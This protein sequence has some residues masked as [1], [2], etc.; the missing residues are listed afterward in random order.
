MPRRSKKKNLFKCAVVGYGSS[1]DT[2]KF[3]CECIR[4]TKGLDLVAVCDLNPERTKVAKKDFPWISTYNDLG[5]M[6]EKQDV[7]L[8]TIVT[9]HNT[10]APLAIQCLKAGKHVIVEKPMCITTAEATDMIN[11]AKK[12]NL[13]LSVFHN[14]RYDG[15]FRA[16]KETVDKKTIGDVFHLEAF[17]GG[18][19]SPGSW[20]RSSKEISGGAFYDWGSHLMDWVLNIIPERIVGLAGFFHKLVWKEVTN[21]DQVE[22]VI[23][24]LSGAVADVQLSNIAS[25]RKPR[26]R[27]LGTRG[28]IVSEPGRKYFK[29][30]T[31]S[32]E[33]PVEKRY[34]SRKP[35]GPCIIGT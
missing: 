8:V 28:G 9:P 29:V 3:H 35:F 12:K 2:S 4:D 6:L 33:K 5:E 13:M 27:I 21:E 17:M 18:Y 31:F 15:D 22:A 14:R 16:L 30:V 1:F 25:I 20:W 34:G 11:E 19:S 23:R 10:H 32:D 26:W 24:F 7:D